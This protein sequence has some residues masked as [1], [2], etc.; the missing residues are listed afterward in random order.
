MQEQKIIDVLR[1]F[2]TNNLKP[3]SNLVQLNIFWRIILSPI[4]LIWFGMQ[5]VILSCFGG[6]FVFVIGFIVLLGS[7]PYKDSGEHRSTAIFFM[8]FPFIAPF[9]WLYRYIRFGEFA[10]LMN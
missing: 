8:L 3:N 2:D 1:S 7:L 5:F 6:A 9:V 10:P 4:M